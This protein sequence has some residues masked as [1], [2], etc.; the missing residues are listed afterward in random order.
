[1]INFGY[2][3][4]A[5]ALLEM[6]ALAID[7]WFPV[8]GFPQM[9][10]AIR[11]IYSLSLIGW[12]LWRVVLLPLIDGYLYG[13]ESPISHKSFARSLETPSPPTY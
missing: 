6:V 11:R 3:S 5:V 1:M 13:H 7:I 9:S 2:Y 8:T 4:Y 12:V 10:M